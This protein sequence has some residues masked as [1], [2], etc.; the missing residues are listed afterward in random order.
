MKKE[1]RIYLAPRAER[2][3]LRSRDLLESS[4]TDTDLYLDL[5]DPREVPTITQ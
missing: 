2:F 5:E 1:T 3:H 4:S